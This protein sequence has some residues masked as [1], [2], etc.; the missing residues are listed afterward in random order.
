MPETG[1]N[2]PPRSCLRAMRS[3]IIAAWLK[4]YGSSASGAPNIW[5]ENI[6]SRA[7]SW[8][9]IFKWRDFSRNSTGESNAPQPKRNQRAAPASRRLSHEEKLKKSRGRLLRL[10]AG[11]MLAP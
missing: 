3:S 9:S 7:R 1:T 10:Q 4:S 8:P 11:K 5:Q 6:P 2:F